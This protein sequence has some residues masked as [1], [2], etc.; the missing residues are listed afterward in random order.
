MCADG[1]SRQAGIPV[2]ASVCLVDGSP[3]R[4]HNG[5]WS[6]RQARL[7][8]QTALVAGLAR[9][10]CDAAQAKATPAVPETTLRIMRKD[11]VHEQAAD[12]T[13]CQQ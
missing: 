11:L 12:P 13:R 1:F 4:Y 3:R 9:Q 8:T 6:R 7:A 5:A 10:D 2:N